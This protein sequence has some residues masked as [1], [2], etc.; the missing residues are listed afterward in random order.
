MAA[1]HDM[2]CRVIEI[3][4]PVRREVVAKLEKLTKETLT[5]TYSISNLTAEMPNQHAAD[6]ICVSTYVPR[7]LHRQL[8]VAAK[9][10]GFETL[11]DFIEHIYTYAT[12]DVELT[13]TDYREIARATEAAKSKGPGADKR[14]RQ[15]GNP[16]ENGQKGAVSKR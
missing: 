13:P 11:T 3:I 15:K 16:H 6:K 12:K 5:V 10:R 14:A 8:Q 7:T 1:T 2:T 4:S 9:K